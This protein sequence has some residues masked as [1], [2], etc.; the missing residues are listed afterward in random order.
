[1]LSVETL[2][3]TYELLKM[4][5]ERFQRYKMV[6][7]QDSRE[8]LF[9]FTQRAPGHRCK[10]TDGELAEVSDMLALWDDDEITVVEPVKPV[11]R[12]SQPSS[13]KSLSSAPAP[14][15]KPSK[16]LAP[17]KPQ[18]V[19]EILSDDE[20][21]DDF[22]TLTEEDLAALD[23]ISSSAV[24]ASS[25]KPRP[26]LSAR[27][28]AAVAPRSTASSSSTTS[29]KAKFP[30]AG[31]SLSSST[32]F[33]PIFPPTSKSYVTGSDAA[34]SKPAPKP[35]AAA[36]PAK[37]AKPSVRSGLMKNL[38]SDFKA[39]RR[40]VGGV[41]P[42]PLAG[43]KRGFTLSTSNRPDIAPPPPKRHTDTQDSGSEPTDSDKSS[44]EEEEDPSRL[45]N[46]VNKATRKPAITTVRGPLTTARSIKMM[47][48]SQAIKSPAQLRAEQREAAHRTHLRLKP[49]LSV[50]HRAI[51]QWNPDDT[52]STPPSLDAASLRRIAPTFDSPADYLATLQPLLMLDCWSQ[53]QKS[54]EDSRSE[55]RLLCEVAG[56]GLVD[57]WAEVDVSYA[58]NQIKQ[59]FFLSET[60]VVLFTPVSDLGGSSSLF[61]KVV[62]S[63]KGFPD[64]QV[65]LRFHSACN[66]GPVS[67]RS[68][69][70]F[71]KVLK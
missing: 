3:Q 36:K 54:R 50:L 30:G 47:P 38:K 51:L 11:G 61:A 60:D 29:S 23:S 70:H 34:S 55:P 21:G 59:V 5:L 48:D 33:A 71:Q 26:A 12:T 14:E 16:E 39:E 4:L 27:P 37:S 18:E 40:T 66:L 42:A 1:M 19:I 68:K 17:K 64:S 25:S 20:F 58:T 32:K 22:P 8:K 6:P 9:A 65:K 49:D 43:P 44:S 52:G 53:L 41:P 67:P 57:D 62:S 45:K 15:L 56:R 31:S 35:V 2:H 24:K 7:N 13:R 10:L 69:W 28:P 46:F 63:T